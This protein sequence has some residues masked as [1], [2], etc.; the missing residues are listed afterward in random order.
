[1][2]KDREA[3]LT[4]EDVPIIKEYVD[5]FPEGLLGFSLERVISFEIELLPK[6]APISKAPYCMAPAKLGKLQVQ[7]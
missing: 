3:E 4:P 2:D 6:A 7:L 5:I 1:M